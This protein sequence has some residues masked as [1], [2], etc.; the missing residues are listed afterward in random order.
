MAI[1]GVWSRFGF[2]ENPYSEATLPADENGHRLL[3]GRDAEIMDIQ[4]RI[5]SGGTHPAV[6][7]PI[8]AGK[9]SLLNVASYRMARHCL[10]VGSKELYLPARERFQPQTDAAA[11]E[12]KVPASD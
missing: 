10:D 4:S 1:F 11:F 5:G 8:G 12:L 6:E 9:T 7:G 3:V 2:R